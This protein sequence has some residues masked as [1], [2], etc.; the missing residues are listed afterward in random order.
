MFIA[1]SVIHQCPYLCFRGLRCSWE[2]LAL[3][4]SILPTMLLEL[5][6]FFKKLYTSRKTERWQF[7]SEKYEKEIAHKVMHNRVK[8]KQLLPCGETFSLE[9]WTLVSYVTL[10]CY[11]LIYS[12]MQ[13]AFFFFTISMILCLNIIFLFCLF[14]RGCI[15]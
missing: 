6:M 2:G 7:A 13:Y 3:L 14:V 12:Q 15:T 8:M 4:D 1:F 10:F 9:E 11:L 5:E